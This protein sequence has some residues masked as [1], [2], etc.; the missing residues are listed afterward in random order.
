MPLWYQLLGG[1][2]P[3]RVLQTG[4]GPRR[5]E[6]R[7]TLWV[8]HGCP[9][10]KRARCESQNRLL[11]VAAEAALFA[12]QGGTTRVV[13]E[14]PEDFGE[15]ELGA[16]ASFWERPGPRQLA[17]LPGFT[18]GA[19]YQCE[20]DA[21][22]EEPRP[23]RL[24]T[25]ISGLFDSLSRGPPIFETGQVHGRLTERRYAGPLHRPCRC[26]VRH[27][28][29][30]KSIG[31]AK[32]ATAAT[33]LWSAGFAAHLARAVVRAS[34]PA[35]TAAVCNLA[36]GARK[37]P[38]PF[39]GQPIR[40]ESSPLAP[41][42]V[43]VGRNPRHGPTLWGNGNKV[44]PGCSAAEACEL[45]RADLRADSGLMAQL[46]TLGGRRLR[47]HCNEGAACHADV[48]IKVPGQSWQRSQRLSR[49]RETRR[50]TA[51]RR[52]PSTLQISPS[53]ASGLLCR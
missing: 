4:E 49:L 13:L 20:L 32:Y 48:L 39:R 38:P 1:L 34:R 2:A 43:Y 11:D 29:G 6:T 37:V 30:L 51:T 22:C 36:V 19:L 23:P 45:Y 17:S 40:S 46:H 8:S 3:E 28:A 16:P 21:A 9:P 33:L 12:S 15:A 26:G 25:N 50:T 35:E 47:C 41:G 24:V 14:H 52:S 7:N 42:D 31:T 18:T 53:A 5:S 10:K 44:R 27:G